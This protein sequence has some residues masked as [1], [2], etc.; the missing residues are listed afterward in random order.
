MRH[1]QM[2]VNLDETFCLDYYEEEFYSADV[3]ATLNKY[4]LYFKSI[5]KEIRKFPFYVTKCNHC[6]QIILTNRDYLDALKCQ[7]CGKVLSCV[8]IDN[9]MNK[10]L[11]KEVHD[12]LGF[13]LQ[14]GEGYVAY[15][16]AFIPEEADISLLNHILKNYGF[17][18]EHCDGNIYNLLLYLGK[19]KNWLTEETK[20]GFCKMNLN[21]KDVIFDGII[22]RVEAC[23][24][25]ITKCFENKVKTAS[26]HLKPS[27]L[28]DDKSSIRYK[29]E[30]RELIER[31]VNDGNLEEALK[32][33]DD[34]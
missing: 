27:L 16:L 12:T 28:N 6:G 13:N 18:A 19:E 2:K 31:L 7:N 10:V 20:V 26:I 23:A 21:E 33:I 30:K 9:N 34:L 14:T 29:A 4:V 5:G 25:A 15:L 1:L 11:L 24:R 32:Q 22:P 17:S 3:A 8:P